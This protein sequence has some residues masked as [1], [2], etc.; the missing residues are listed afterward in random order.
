MIL[1]K[2]P[3]IDKDTLF[4]KDLCHKEVITFLKDLK[5]LQSPGISP[6]EQNSGIT[7]GRRETWS[8]AVYLWHKSLWLFFSC[9]SIFFLQVYLHSLFLLCFLPFSSQLSVMRSSGKNRMA[10]MESSKEGQA[11]RFRRKRQRLELG[12]EEEMWIESG[13]RDWEDRI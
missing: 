13:K 5:H 7:N 10:L 6:H 8:K 12:L 4:L 9:T 2:Q 11:M 3:N 1:Y